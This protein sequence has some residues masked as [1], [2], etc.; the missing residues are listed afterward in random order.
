MREA[1]TSRRETE[2]RTHA[3][4]RRKACFVSPGLAVCER[5][6]SPLASGRAG[7]GRRPPAGPHADSILLAGRD[8]CTASPGRPK[9]TSSG[10]R[11]P[12]VEQPRGATGARRLP[13]TR[14]PLLAGRGSDARGTQ[15]LRVRHSCGRTEA[16]ATRRT[17]GWRV[18]GG[19]R[20][21]AGYAE[22][23]VAVVNPEPAARHRRHSARMRVRKGLC[24]PAKALK[25]RS[26]CPV[27]RSMNGSPYTAE[28][29][30]RWRRNAWLSTSLHTF[31]PTT[32]R[33]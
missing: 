14:R 22:S 2:G 12:G 20:C 25:G 26:R 9:E 17:S 16:D 30:A 21:A 6:S 13:K 15:S 11:A 18:L 24:P 31:A 5:P 33:R 29:S 10:L 23:G 1:A 19:E 3:G 32:L 28:V 27:A 7:E 8:S 4:G